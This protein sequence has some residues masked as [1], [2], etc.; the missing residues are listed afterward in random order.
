MN[1]I[2]FLA[3]FF[4]SISTHPSQDSLAHCPCS[5]ALS[6]LR[7]WETFPTRLHFLKGQMDVYAV[8]RLW[9]NF[10]SVEF[11]KKIEQ[12]LWRFTT[13]G[14]LP[15]Y[16]MTFFSKCKTVS[17]VNIF[18]TSSEISWER[19]QFSVFPWI[20]FEDLAGVWKTGAPSKILRGGENATP[21]V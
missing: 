18:C 5:G 6:V 14:N 2:L 4:F 10:S 7:L 13:L 3:S 15:T 8:L 21:L 20:H 16:Q 12:L 11:L 9:E 19:F 1:C 17:F